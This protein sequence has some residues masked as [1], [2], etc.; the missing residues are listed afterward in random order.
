MATRRGYREGMATARRGWGEGAVYRRTSD[1]QWVGSVEL[2][3]DHRGRR[4]RR[5]VYGRTKRE[6]LDKLDIARRDRR[7]GLEP[8]DQRLTTGEW[9]D[10]W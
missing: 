4:R 8:I 9:L 2:G 3:R 10:R 5:T 1:G 7:R 6:A